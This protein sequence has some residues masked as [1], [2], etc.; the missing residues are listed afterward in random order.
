MNEEDVA[1]TKQKTVATK[2]SIP[3]CRSTTVTVRLVLHCI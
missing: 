2:Y 3:T 1:L